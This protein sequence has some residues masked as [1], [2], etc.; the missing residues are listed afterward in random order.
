MGSACA[1]FLYDSILSPKG[2]AGVEHAVESQVNVGVYPPAPYYFGRFTN[3]Y[4]WVDVAGRILG[5]EV[6]NYAAGGSNGNA[7]GEITVDPPFAYVPG[8]TRVASR[9]LV[10]QV[11]LQYLKTLSILCLFCPLL[12]YRPD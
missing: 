4:I 10:E 8:P 6:D 12:F 5:Q 1:G 7:A 9:S 11:C 3:G 2:S